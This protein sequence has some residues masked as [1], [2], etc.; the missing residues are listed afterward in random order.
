MGGVIILWA[1]GACVIRGEITIGGLITFNSLLV[2]FLDPIKNLINLQ[3][4][5]QTAVVAVDHLGEILDL[6]VEKTEAEYRKLSP[7]KLTG[8]IE[9]R[10]LDFRYGKRKQVLEN[11]NLKIEKGQ[12]V[13][14]VGESGSR[15]TTLSK[16]LLHMYSAE[17]GEILIDGNNEEQKNQYQKDAE[18]IRESINDCEERIRKYE[19][20][21]EGIINRNN[22][23]ELSDSFFIVL[24][25][26]LFPI[27]RQRNCSIIIR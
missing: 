4:Q 24:S 27:M 6:E 21:K 17:K 19:Q 18:S 13:V 14:F 2:Y 8:E 3:P 23:F 1:G 11:I 5:I 16:L 20:T 22:S 9:I 25:T 10:N 12:K 26:A 7:D 15:K